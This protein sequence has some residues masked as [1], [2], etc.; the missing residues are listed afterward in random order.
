MRFDATG[1]RQVR[2]LPDADL[3]FNAT[4]IGSGSARFRTRSSGLSMGTRQSSTPCT[5]R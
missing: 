1:Y 4:P 3:I 2:Q 5:D